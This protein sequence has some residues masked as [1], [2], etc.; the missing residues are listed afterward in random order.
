MLKVTRKDGRHQA[1]VLGRL[2]IFDMDDEEFLNTLL[3][4]RIK[5]IVDYV[6]SPQLRNELLSDM[7][8]VWQAVKR[9]YSSI[10]EAR[11]IFSA[12]VSRGLPNAA[13]K[14]PESS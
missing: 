2:T 10:E 3:D 9:R 8:L 7:R 13:E 5:Q 11:R 14:E 4:A 6:P 1:I 12:E